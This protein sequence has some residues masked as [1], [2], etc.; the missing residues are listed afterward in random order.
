M[1]A[2]I[3]QVSISD[4]PIPTSQ[5]SVCSFV[6]RSGLLFA[7][8]FGGSPYKAGEEEPEALLDIFK[9]GKFFDILLFN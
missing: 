7:A 3:G 1:T 4:E 2:L 9:Y 8:R 6:A 5:Q